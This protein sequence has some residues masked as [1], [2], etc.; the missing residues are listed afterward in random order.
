[1]ASAAATIARAAPVDAAAGVTVPLG[2]SGLADRRQEEDGG[3]RAGDRAVDRVRAAA[4][5]PAA[6]APAPS[7]GCDPPSIFA[8]V[9]PQYHAI[10]ENDAVYGPGFVEWSLLKPVADMFDGYRTVRPHADIGYYNLLDRG[11]RKYMRVLADHY[12][13]DGFIFYHYWFTS[14][15]VLQRPTE[16]MLLDGE[17]DKPFF[18]CWANEGWSRSFDGSERDVVLEHKWGDDAAVAAH[19]RYVARFF[20]H[21]NYVKVRNRPV[22]SLY[23][24]AAADAEGVARY[25]RAWDAAARQ[26][27]FDGVHFLKFRGPFEDYDHPDVDGS[28]EVQPGLGQRLL[29]Q[30]LGTGWDTNVVKIDG[31]ALTERVTLR[32]KASLAK[33][34]HRSA[35]P[36]WSNHV[37]KSSGTRTVMYVNTTFDGFRDA[38][39][40]NSKLQADECNPSGLNL[41]ALTAW[42]EWNEQAMLEPSDLYGYAALSAVR[43]ARA[44]LKAPPPAAKGTILHMMHLGGG[45]ERYARDL[46]RAFTDYRHEVVGAANL[47][48]AARL[49]GRGAIVLHIH[50]AQAS[51]DHPALGWDVLALVAYARPLVHKVVLTVHD[52]QWLDMARPNPTQAELDGLTLSKDALFNVSQLFTQADT[53]IFPTRNVLNNY[54]AALGPERMAYFDTVVTPHPDYHVAYANARVPAVRQGVC[55][56]AFIGDFIPTK[57]ASTFLDVVKR[58]D[59]MEAGPCKAVQFYVFGEVDPRSEFNMDVLTDYDVII[60]PTDN[61]RYVDAKLVGLLLRHQIHVL[62]HLSAVPETYCYALTHSINSGLPIVYTDRGAFTERLDG[63]G[64]RFFKAATDGDVFGQMRAAMASLADTA[65]VDVA[66]DP[67][68]VEPSRWYLENYPVPR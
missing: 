1:V 28:I 44:M 38:M 7:T 6:Y 30:E 59:D 17:P 21:P 26:A 29:G 13:V 40:I 42:N 36:S 22:F 10:P 49:A 16:R 27:G 56:I 11:H 15:P 9:F 47:E 39:F 51:P 2:R 48:A 61:G 37:R 53:V 18:F 43:D 63:R 32:R 66:H 57:G 58:S 62:L 68:S 65:R 60:N 20:K 25:H 34:V 23:R 31:A 35:F 5:A 33:E 8:I 19:F 45:T 4:P 41:M 3:G 67:A 46:M 54:V 24:V 50:S 14:G 64:D 12:G 55:R 52:Y